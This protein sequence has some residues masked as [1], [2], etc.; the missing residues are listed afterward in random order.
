MKQK[1]PHC[2]AFCIIKVLD[3]FHVTNFLVMSLTHKISPSTRNISDV[4]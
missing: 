4:V 2:V 3:L 1:K